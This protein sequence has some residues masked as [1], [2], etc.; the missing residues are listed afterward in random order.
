MT[1]EQ[2]QKDMMAAMKAHDKERKDAISSLVSAVK[3]N[4]IDAGRYGKQHDLKRTE[5]CTGADR[6]L[7][8]GQNRADRRVPEAS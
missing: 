1:I 8:E 2:L 6:Y 4:A 3:K 7:P 5:D